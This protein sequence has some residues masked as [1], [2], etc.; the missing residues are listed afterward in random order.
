MNWRIKVG[1]LT[2][3]SIGWMTI[4]LW[5]KYRWTKEE[6]LWTE[7][8]SAAVE[9]IWDSIRDSRFGIGSS[10]RKAGQ[11]TWA[12][13][14]KPRF[15]AFGGAFGRGSCN[16]SLRGRLSIANDI[17][18]VSGRP[19]TLT[20]PAGDC[21]EWLAELLVRIGGGGGRVGPF[22]VS[23]ALPLTKSGLFLSS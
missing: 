19:T 16:F 17:E 1:L 8:L 3:L 6:Y 4:L 18:W 12:G 13:W 7:I 10:A 14:W 15:A 20:L 21:A 11:R 9:E 22:R 23:Y 2:E 5:I